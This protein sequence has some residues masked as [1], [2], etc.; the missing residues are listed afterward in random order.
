MPIHISGHLVRLDQLSCDFLQLSLAVISRTYIQLQSACLLL[1]FIF[2]LDSCLSFNL[3]QAAP[4]LLLKESCVCWVNQLSQLVHLGLQKL[5][6]ALVG[7]LLS[8]ALRS[9]ELRALRD[10]GQLLVCS[11]K[12]LLIV[13]KFLDLK[14][15]IV[16]L[17]VLRRNNV[18]FLGYLVRLEKD[19]SLANVSE[20]L[21]QHLSLLHAVLEDEVHH[22]HVRVKDRLEQDTSLDALYGDL[23]SDLLNGNVVSDLDQQVRITLQD[24]VVVSLLSWENSLGSILCNSILAFLEL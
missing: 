20:L 14:K 6:L 7:K 17:P 9:L 24:I 2:V 19:L 8:L 23:P 5:D 3:L 18:I 12:C 10:R 16:D 11:L 15:Q 22:A 13:F 1:H 21:R 4:S